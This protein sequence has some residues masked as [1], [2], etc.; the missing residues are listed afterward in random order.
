MLDNLDNVRKF[1][2]H[3][4]P[5]PSTC[6]RR[7]CSIRSCTAAIRETLA[8]RQ[9]GASLQSKGVRGT[10]WTRVN[11]GFAFVSSDGRLGPS[12]PTALSP[13]VWASSP[14]FRGTGAR[15]PPMAPMRKIC[16]AG[17]RSSPDQKGAGDHQF[18]LIGLGP[19]SFAT[20]VTERRVGRP[21]QTAKAQLIKA[22]AHSASAL[23]ELK[24][25]SA[26][27]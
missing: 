19:D 13:R 18:P 8:P 23:Q 24:A 7:H 6:R 4:L 9:P 26:E 25:G 27:A 21:S 12:L 10:P 3:P 2:T 11:E 17:R 1:G 20:A 22:L 5:R 14:T 15:Q 16:A